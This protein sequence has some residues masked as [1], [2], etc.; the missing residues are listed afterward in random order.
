MEPVILLIVTTVG[1]G[2][3]GI[4]FVL[5]KAASQQPLP[6][7]SEWID[8]LSI[9]RYRPML[10]LLSEDDLRFL[11]SQPGFTPEMARRFRAQ[12]SQIFRGYLRWLQNDFDRVCAALRLLMLQ[13]HQDRPDLATILLKQRAVFTLGMFEVRVRLQLYRWGVAGVDVAAVIRSFDTLRLE[14]RQ[15]VPAQAAASI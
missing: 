11:Q 5:R 9:E 10:R 14:L 13:S 1:A 15:M 6:V 12:R 2:A 4:A 8:E 7:T 3:L